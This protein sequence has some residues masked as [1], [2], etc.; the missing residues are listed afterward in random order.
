MSLF[1]PETANMT[2]IGSVRIPEKEQGGQWSFAR[3][4]DSGPT[5]KGVPGAL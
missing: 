5:C 4:T 1:E 3:R 2:E